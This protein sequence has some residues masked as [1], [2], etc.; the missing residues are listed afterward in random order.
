VFSEQQDKTHDHL[1]IRGYSWHKN[2]K[3]R[4][5][6]P[7]NLLAKKKKILKNKPFLKKK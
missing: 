2:E 3:E 4:I 5:Q 6:M 7:S 1:S